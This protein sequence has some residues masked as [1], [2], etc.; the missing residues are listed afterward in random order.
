M[1]YVLAFVSIVAV[2]VLIRISALKK[3]VRKISEQLR[4]YIQHRA[5]KKIDV[6]LV[7]RD[8]EHLSAEINEL[9]ELHVIEKRERARHENEQQQTIANMSHD[10]RTPLTSILGYLQLA[11]SDDVTDSERKEYISIA[12]R[13]AQRLEALIHDFFELSVIESADQQLKLKTVNMTT[14]TMDVLMSFYDRFAETNKVP[15]LDI[16]EHDIFL[17]SDESAITRVIENLIANALT[18]SDGDIR[19]SLK[20]NGQTVQFVVANVASALTQQDVDRFFD[21][22]Y[23]A[24]QSRSGNNTGLGLSIVKSFMMKM[25][26]TVTGTLEN[27]QLSIRCDWTRTMQ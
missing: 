9:I 27:G 25:N 12:K 17:I 23:M 11:E 16:P 8:I 26:G 13:R 21:R 3:E 2:F 1:V 4:K 14:L 15:A 24:D 7:D 6:A 5:G 22:F 10:L 19:V 18:H 20:D